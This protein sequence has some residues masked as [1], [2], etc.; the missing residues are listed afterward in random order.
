MSQTNDRH[1]RHHTR[2]MQKALSE[3]QQHLRQ[4]AEKVDEP[5][6]RA[7]RDLRRSNRRTDEG[8]SR[9][10]TEER[11][12]LAPLMVGGSQKAALAMRGSK[13]SIADPGIGAACS[14]PEN[15]AAP[16]NMPSSILMRLI[17]LSIFLENQQ[18]REVFDP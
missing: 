7:V 13:E 12:R 4:D 14:A 2:K 1:P 6:L 11:T 15:N 18:P 10:R 3:I 5:Q 17:V 9:L 8:V 16:A